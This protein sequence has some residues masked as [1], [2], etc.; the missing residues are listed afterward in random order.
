MTDFRINKTIKV[1]IIVNGILIPLFIFY[2]LYKE[3]SDRY[4]YD[5]YE[6][7]DI[8]TGEELDAAIKD[9][10]ALQGLYY[11]SPAKIYNSSNYFLFIAAKTYEERREF[12]EALKMQGDIRIEEDNWLN[13]VFLDKDLKVIGNL[14]DRKA[15]ISGYW[16]NAPYDRDRKVELD[17]TVKHIAYSIGFEDSNEDGRLNSLDDHDLYISDLSGKNLTQVTS[18]VDVVDFSFVDDNSKILVTYLD[19]VNI[20]AEY[21]RNK[22]SMYD[23]RTQTLSK[24]KEIENQLRAI[25]KTLILD[26]P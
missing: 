23:I 6:P 17:T 14:L 18:G 20:R 24:T 22:F 7:E 11:D 1:L 25:E 5:S 21:K 9:S 26:R 2:G 16:I 10:V 8:I 19:R 3:I 15:T 4:S 13:I 12:T